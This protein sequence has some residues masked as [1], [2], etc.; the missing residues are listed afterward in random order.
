[1]GN[2][3]KTQLKSVIQNDNLIHLNALPFTCSTVTPVSGKSYAGLGIR[4]VDTVKVIAHSPGY[5]ALTVG[6]LD[7]PASR[8]TEK[9][10]T[11]SD[12]QVTLY[13][14]NADYVVEV[15]NEDKIS[16]LGLSPWNGYCPFV[17]KMDDI[18]YCDALTDI[19]L[20]KTSASGDIKALKDKSLVSAGFLH[21]DGVYGD[22]SALKNMS[23]LDSVNITSSGV[24]GDFAIFGS[25]AIHKSINIV[26]TEVTGKIEDWVHNHIDDAGVATSNKGDYVL[27]LLKFASLNGKT[28]QE[29]GYWTICYDSIDKIYV[30]NGT[31]VANFT[32]IYTKG[33]TAGEIATKTASGGAWEGKTAIRTED[34]E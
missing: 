5:F 23:N 1:M 30:G 4:T 8:L 27:D 7:D 29:S 6:G 25:A 20:N 3:F 31:T 9:T 14:A 22:I 32:K 34:T 15:L 21:N 12:G 28:Y 16:A 2:C 18:T 19:A 13:F 26:G 33:Y 17:I 10:I 11:S 24:Y